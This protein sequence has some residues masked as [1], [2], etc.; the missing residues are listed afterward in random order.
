[1]AYSVP[2]SL[3]QAFARHQAGDIAGAAAM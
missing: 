2:V 1:M 3:E